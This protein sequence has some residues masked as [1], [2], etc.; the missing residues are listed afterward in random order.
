MKEF[1]ILQGYRVKDA[2]AR[3]FLTPEMYGAKM[4]GSTD[5]SAAF[6]QM[7]NDA[8]AKN[9]PVVLK[10]GTYFFTVPVEIPGR[11]FLEGNNAI[12]KFTT[13]INGL[14]MTNT[15]PK[16]IIKDL[17]ITS[18]AEDFTIENTTG[19][20]VSGAHSIF[21]N[22]DIS[23]FGTGLLY[24]DTLTTENQ[25]GVHYDH[26]QV[27]YC[28]YDGLNIGTDGNNK[29]TDAYLSN[30]VAAANRYGI[31]IGS[32]IGY[33]VDNIHI[34]GHPLAGIR[35]HD[36]SLSN[37][38]NLY[39]EPCVNQAFNM[40]TRKG[41]NISNVDVVTYASTYGTSLTDAIFRIEGPSTALVSAN[42]SN[43]GIRT[44]SAE[45]TKP[46]LIHLTSNTSNVNVSNVYDSESLKPWE[47]YDNA[48]SITG[49]VYNG[50]SLRGEP[51]RFYGEF[52]GN[53]FPASLKST[54]TYG[55]TAAAVS[56]DVS[57]LAVSY[58]FIIKVYSAFRTDDSFQ[59]SGFHL[60]SCTIRQ[61][62]TL[63]LGTVKDVLVNEKC[64]VTATKSGNVVTVTGT[65]AHTGAL[66]VYIEVLQG[67]P[68]KPQ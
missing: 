50:T 28:G 4:N 45:A 7:M 38:S 36:C 66:T 65:K 19:L 42:I 54:V 39:I 32:C 24:D 37:F 60:L 31:N 10:S 30:I 17:V 5:D 48:A 64:T 23:N 43:V 40:H 47:G 41:F 56:V 6:N 61:D 16:S 3:Y 67:I 55:E 21:Q 26:I 53:V 8:V 18:T 62:G 52:L 29:S 20:T 15:G 33:K 22:L 11:I 25:T 14:V 44:N 27:R 59:Y 34:W 49:Y 51:D 57:G 1:S 2:I 63:E 68:R 12:L 9:L 13:G 35:T 58:P 46:K